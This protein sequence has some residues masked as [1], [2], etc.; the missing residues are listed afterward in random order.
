M[1]PIEINNPAPRNAIAEN[2]ARNEETSRKE[3]ET[4]AG[5]MDGAAPSNIAIEVAF[6][7]IAYAAHL[8]GDFD[9]SLIDA[10]T[11][12]EAREALDRIES[13]RAHLQQI[14]PIFSK[15]P[16]IAATI[17][18][19]LHTMFYAEATLIPF[20]LA[21]NREVK[22]NAGG[23]VKTYIV[24][25]PVTGM[26]KIGRSADVERRIKALQTGAGAALSIVAILDGDHEAA[27]HARF[28][29][30]RRH[31]EWFEDADGKIASFAETMRLE[32]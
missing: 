17:K 4:I 23:Q 26:L 32:A 10:M 27:L 21:G 28:A 12:G 2:V 16:L 9:T 18:N 22:Q 20:Y 1:S 5:L 24:S 25:N 7:S 6:K 3:A 8:A 15:Y 19:L 11:K 29:G 14:E 13:G 30:M 31:G